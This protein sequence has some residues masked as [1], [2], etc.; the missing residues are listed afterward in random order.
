MSPISGITSSSL[1]GLNAPPPVQQQP[2]QPT[3]QAPKT[4]TVSISAQAQKLASDGDTRVQE[5]TEK[6]AEKSSESVRG[7]A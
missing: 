3:Q 2:S 1:I 7:K 5:V 6:A 4:D